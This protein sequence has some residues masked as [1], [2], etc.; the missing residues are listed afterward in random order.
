MRV[1][2]APDDFTGTL[3]APEAAAAIARGWL[4]HD[5]R[6]DLD[7]APMSDGGPGFLD[8]LEAALGGT[9]HHLPA[10]GPLGAALTAPVLSAG[11]GTV[12]VEAALACGLALVP[13]AERRPMDATTAGVGDL[14]RGSFD[15]LAPERVVVGVGGTASTDGG[16]GCVTA[17]GGL[18]RWP[19]GVPLVAATDVDNPLLGPSGA[20]RMFAQQKG[21]SAS[22][23]EALE[24]ALEQ[25]S[26]EVGR[27]DPAAAGTGAG[28][29]LGFGLLALG[30]T[31][32]SGVQLVLDAVRLAE[33][34]AAADL[35]LTGEGS[36]DQTSLLGKVPRGVAWVAQRAARPCVVLAGRVL[37]GRREFAAAGVDAAY[38]V[39]DRVGHHQSG[40]GSAADRLAALT[41]Q[42]A[43]TWSPRPAP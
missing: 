39:D 2:V 23:V 1:L 29:G 41:E 30:G 7:L 15:R 42:V 28:G 19:P 5:P 18:H 31:R 17:L 12:Y 38:A 40:A 8:V 20:A 34:A 9:R 43:A 36:F 27:V 3:T 33:R 21:A 4:R 10:T 37:V 26:A 32:V 6:A 35:V 14:L 22:Q 25:W 13:P 24:R 16:R 11:D